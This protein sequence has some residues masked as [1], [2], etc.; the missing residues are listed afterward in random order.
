MGKN[1]KHLSYEDRMLI[2]SRLKDRYSLIAIAREFTCSP[3]TI[4]NETKRGSTLLYNGTKRRYKASRGQKVYEEN[5]KASCHHYSYLDKKAFIELVEKKFFSTGGFLD[6]C[7]G[8]ALIAG[9][10]TRNQVVCTKTL[11]NYVDMGPLNI[12]NHN[13]SMKLR[14]KTKKHLLRLNK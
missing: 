8:N 7:A 9:D 3:I 2:Q 1:E 14:R 6:V 12:R 4:S 5:R 13:L 10:F 11:Y